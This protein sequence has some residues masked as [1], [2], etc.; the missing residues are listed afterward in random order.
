[1]KEIYLVNLQ[2]I[3]LIFIVDSSIA[4]NL[5]PAQIITKESNKSVKIENVFINFARC[6]ADP[7]N[8]S[9]SEFK[10]R[11]FENKINSIIKPI[12][13]RVGMMELSLSGKIDSIITNLTSEPILQTKIE[14]LKKEL[15][16]TQQNL[17]EKN[18]MIEF[19]KKIVSALV[20]DK[21]GFVEILPILDET[22]LSITGVD[23]LN[24]QTVIL[25]CMATKFP[26]S[27]GYFTY[28]FIINPCELLQENSKLPFNNSDNETRF[29]IF[30]ITLTCNECNALGQAY[31]LQD[32]FSGF[33]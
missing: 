16:Q 17:R 23:E 14:V 9:N 4:Y 33:L 1:M 25:E 22:H 12:S 31:E 10:S 8:T 5:F 18:E 7:L 21:A 20:D 2:L 27:T 26:N 3:F 15:S 32:I 29:P 28:P 19:M 11:D 24:K 13:D 6:N 30:F